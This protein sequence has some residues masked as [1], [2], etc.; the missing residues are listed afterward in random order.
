MD[1]NLHGTFSCSVCRHQCQ[2]GNVVN[3]MQLELMVETAQRFLSTSSMSQETSTSC[4]K[5]NHVLTVFC[6]DDLQLLCEQCIG[7]ASHNGHRVSPIAQAASHHR[8]KLQHFSRSL[9]GQLTVVQKLSHVQSIRTQALKEQAEAQRRSLTSEFKKLN[10]FLDR[11]QQA[12]FSRLEEEEKA[13]MQKMIENI[14]AFEN[15]AS[16]LRD[17]LSYTVEA[18]TLSDLELMGTVR[19]FYQN[20]KNL[21]DVAIFA[22]Q[23]RREAYN[24]PLQYS[25]LQKVI[26][27]FT[28]DVTL[29]PNTAHPNLLV[30]EDKKCVTYVEEKLHF[31]YSVTR[32]TNSEV[33]LGLP[34]FSSGRHFWEVKVGMKPQ[35]AVG[36][37]KANLSTWA[38][39]FSSPQ[40][41]CSIIWQGDGFNVSGAEPHFAELKAT[42][43]RSIGVFLDYELG[44]VSFYS[45]PTKSHICTFRDTFA[46]PVYPYFYVGPNSEPLRLCSATDLE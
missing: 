7:C 38:S 15:H 39:Q 45:M 32:F 14:E 43:P 42:R 21:H 23:L 22:P 31:P 34:Y 46:D 6:E 37:F 16:A 33:V 2:V 40:G 12:A 19:N 36:I 4:E 24:F 3:N 13:L 28:V 29:D 25:A 17:H 5:H 1:S 18:R 27:Q 11:E 8:E 20:S 26:E 30:S 9:K 10:S 35:W 41:C 44:E